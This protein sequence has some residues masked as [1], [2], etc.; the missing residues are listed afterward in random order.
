MRKRHVQDQNNGKNPHCAIG[1]PQKE[2]YRGAA[3]IT[4]RPAIITV[5]LLFDGAKLASLRQIDR[6]TDGKAAISDPN[7]RVGGN[8][9]RRDLRWEF[10]DLHVDEMSSV[11]HNTRI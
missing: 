5:P 11:F 6:L 8:L 7:N 1:E 3:I 2:R 4:L 10:V 9:T